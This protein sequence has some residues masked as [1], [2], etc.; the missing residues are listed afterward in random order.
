MHKHSGSLTKARAERARIYNHVLDVFRDAYKVKPDHVLTHP[1]V[2]PGDQ[3]NAD[4]IRLAGIMAM[5]LL[6]MNTVFIG[7]L[8]EEIRKKVL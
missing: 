4:A 1:G 6:M 7:G 3:A 2:N 8:R 5:Q